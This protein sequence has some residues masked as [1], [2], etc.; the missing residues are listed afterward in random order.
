[1][2]TRTRARNVQARTL[3]SVWPWPM[4][5]SSAQPPSHSPAQCIGHAHSCHGTCCA[6][7]LHRI[8][9]AAE[10]CRLAA[11]TYRGQFQRCRKG[12]ADGRDG[13]APGRLVHR[14]AAT[15]QGTLSQ[16]GTRSAH[17]A[18]CLLRVAREHLLA[19]AAPHPLFGSTLFVCLLVCL[20][21]CLFVCLLATGLCKTNRRWR[22]LRHTRVVAR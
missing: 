18:S 1:M 17:A 7:Q 13:G 12:A 20:L 15:L 8:A 10:Q 11:L 21:V 5:R 19:A 4:R 2:H 9:I 3:L 16:M 22:G 14:A 6:Q